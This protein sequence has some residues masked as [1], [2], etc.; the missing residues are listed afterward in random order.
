MAIRLET[1]NQV[2]KAELDLVWIIPIPLTM[3][4]GLPGAVKLPSVWQC[5]VSVPHPRSVESTGDLLSYFIGYSDQKFSIYV[6]VHTCLCSTGADSDATLL[7][8]AHCSALQKPD[9]KKLRITAPS[10]F[11]K[12]VYDLHASLLHC[13]PSV[14]GLWTANKA[15]SL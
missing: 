4:R 13:R 10:H 9:R 6:T 7:S 5:S 1:A 12:V 14:L 15:S 3:E 8:K 2:F 11:L